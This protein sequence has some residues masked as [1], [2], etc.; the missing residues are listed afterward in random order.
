M[1][2]VLGPLDIGLS[3]GLVFTWAVLALSLAFRLL[4]FPDL[5]IEGS[6]AIGAAV[7]AKLVRNGIPLLAAVAVALAVGM[8]SGALTA[9]LHVRFK[10]N[11]F[12]AGI[13]VV[14][15]TYSLSLRLMGSSNISLLQSPS[16]L[17]IA[18]PLDSFF[19]GSFR[20][21]TALFLT[22]LLVAS[23]LLIL[24][25]ISSRYGM[26]LRAAGSNPS[27]AR[28]VGISVAW[29][30]VFGLAITNGLAAFSGILL[31]SYQGFSDAGMGGGVLILSIAAMTI[32]ERLLPERSMS[33]PMYVAVAAVLGSIVYQVIVA[34]AIWLGLAPTDLK[35][36]T[37]ML[38]MVVVAARFSRDGELFAEGFR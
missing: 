1:T 36:V 22:V 26:R 30:T 13:I 21:G 5:T 3:M 9:F 35:L 27:F 15:V 28:S 4:N 10:M 6:L 33:F 25:G 2:D 34:Y 20:L 14:S 19:G 32:G 12:L 18:Q 29:N 11:K 24:F 37:A 8:L 23:M 7:F 38:V 31:S 17:D 16:L